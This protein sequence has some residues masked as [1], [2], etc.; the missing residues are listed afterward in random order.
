VSDTTAGS[1]SSGRFIL[2]IPPR[3]H[4]AL[5]AAAAAAG[6]SL[7]EYC[8]RKLAAAP[9]NLGEPGAAAAVEQAADLFGAH[10]VAVAAFGSWARGTLGDESDVDLLV[11]VDPEAELTRD[12]Y[13]RWDERPLLWGG[14][15]VEPHFARLGGDARPA[16]GLWAE[17]AVDG[18]VLFDRGF[19]LS[20]RLARLRGEIAAGRLLRRQVHGQPYWVE[21]A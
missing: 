8:S 2:R 16:P 21:A 4:T 15:P 9:A 6:I 19:E 13:R 5:R 11:V 18:V 10:L 7:N 14:R 3:L 12:L 17:V 20:R 1:E